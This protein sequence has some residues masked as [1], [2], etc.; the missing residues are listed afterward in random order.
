MFPGSNKEYEAFLC[1]EVWSLVGPKSAKWIIIIIN[2]ANMFHKFT[3]HYSQYLLI[4]WFTFKCIRNSFDCISDKSFSCL[5][6]IA[7]IDEI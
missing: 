7:H 5:I 1:P 4:C 3:S 6:L 2:L